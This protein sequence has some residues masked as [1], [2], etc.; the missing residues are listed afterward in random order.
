MSKKTAKIT[1]DGKDYILDI[2]KAIKEE[3]LTPVKPIFIGQ[4]YEFDDE[5]YILS[6]CCYIGSG[7]GGGGFVGLMCLNDGKPFGDLIYVKDVHNITQYEWVAMRGENMEHV[8]DKI[9][10]IKFA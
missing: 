10:D 9:F 2:D 7:G 8:A 3:Y 1:I 4:I 5:Y 6:C